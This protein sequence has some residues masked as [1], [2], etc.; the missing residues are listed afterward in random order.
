MQR[1][2]H[3]SFWM[4]LLLAAGITFG[5]CSSN[6]GTTQA[7]SADNSGGLLSKLESPKPV[8]IPAGTDLHVI[9]DTSL[10]TASAQAGDSFEATITEPVVIGGK[11]VIPKDARAKGMVVDARSS[12]RLSKPALL[13]VALS[14]VQA[15]GAWVDVNTDPL[16]LEGK[17]HKKRDVVAIGGG[18]A[19]GA[20]IGGIAGG[21]KGA[22][23]GAAAG[24][25]AGTAGAAA[26]G[27]KEITLPAESHATF[28]TSQPVTVKVK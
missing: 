1:P 13:S 19:L 14:S 18:S 11:T 7:G 15:D 10:S 25:G 20:L 23:I 16:T 6:S 9:L 21:G 4:S 17:S 22:A 2:I 12:G 8:T 26:T 5:G 28:R 24:A 27:K 3:A